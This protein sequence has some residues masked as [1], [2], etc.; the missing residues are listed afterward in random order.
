MSWG[1]RERIKELERDNK[2]LRDFIN[3]ELNCPHCGRR[4]RIG[5]SELQLIP[6][7]TRWPD[8]APT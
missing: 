6:A 2:I 8:G 4:S 1:L 3:K 5:E 7:T